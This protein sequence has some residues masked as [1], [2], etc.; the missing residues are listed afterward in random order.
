MASKYLHD[1][2]LRRDQLKKQIQ[3]LNVEIAEV[4]SIIADRVFEAALA[5]ANEA[6]TRKNRRQQQFTGLI[7]QILSTKEHAAGLKSREL[8]DLLVDDYTDLKYASLRSYVRHMKINGQLYQKLRGA[9]W[10]LLE[11]KESSE[12]WQ[13]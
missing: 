2:K 12:Q 5:G 4:N 7:R 8:Y 13:K 3:R 9:P 1:L 10:Q 11:K 6:P